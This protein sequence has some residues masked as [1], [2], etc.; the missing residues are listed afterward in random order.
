MTTSSTKPE[1]SALTIIYLTVFLDLLGFGI[2]L[3]FLPYWIQELD[4]NVFHVGLVL[5]CYSIAQIFGSSIMGYFSDRFGRR[6]V[7][8][9]S[10][11]GVATGM[12]L[13]GLAS[14][15]VALTLARA[16]AGLF[17]GSVATA[18]AYIADLTQA[19]DRARYMG[20]IGASIGLGFVLG[21]AI[22]AGC[23][24][25]GL[26]FPQAAFGAA[27]LALGNLVFAAFKLKESLPASGP[28]R[29][30]L[31]FGAWVHSLQRPGIRQVLLA[32][33]ATMLAFVAMETTYAFL[34]QKIYGLNERGFALVLTFVGVI[35]V[36]VQG[37]LIGRLTTRFGVRK[38]AI[39]GCS[40]MALSLGLLPYTPQDST[41]F[42]LAA[43][44]LLA[45]SQGL[46]SPTLPT[47]LSNLTDEDSQGRV[48]GVGRSMGA[49]ARAVGPL[50]AG[51]LYD[52]RI[53]APYLLGGALALLATI[54]ILNV[55]SD[56][57]AE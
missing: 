38:I 30:R 20:M 44:A 33:F 24:A 39:A 41:V 14:S 35:M 49:L 45:V 32:T 51:W 48:L 10:L 25:L 53:D 40:L 2:I 43:I 42:A 16:F 17:A 13:S 27:A 47:I 7:L 28:S 26:G 22:G 15:L 56:R 6:P 37:G 1:R 12:V 18:Q 31:T 36:I 46:S 54:L 50:A 8:L 57:A 21:P 5:S 55:S 19:E 11:A 9:V 34:G 52:R 23:A 3:P 4:G 29:K